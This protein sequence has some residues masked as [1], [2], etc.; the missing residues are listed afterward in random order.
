MSAA[1]AIALSLLAAEPLKLAAPGLSGVDVSEA[2]ATFFSDHFAQQLTLRGLQVTTSSQ[3][4]TLLGF[5]RQRNLLGCKETGGSCMAE[6]A[7]ALGV[8]GV[9]TG[10]VGKFDQTFQVNVSVVSALDGRTLSAF[11]RKVNGSAAVL[12]ALNDAADQMARDLP[13]VLKR[14]L[15]PLSNPPE[16]GK[17][18]PPHQPIAP[19]PTSTSS[20]PSPHDWFWLPGGLGLAAGVG[21][22]VFLLR[23]AEA[24]QLRIAAA[25]PANHR[26]SLDQANTI[27]AGGRRALRWGTPW[28]RSPPWALAPPGICSSPAPRRNLSQSGSSRGPPV[29]WSPVISDESTHSLR[30]FN[31]PPA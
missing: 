28:P 10:S 15:A 27:R 17:V 25:D 6:L 5:E 20:Q 9:V 3:I 11:S 31:R 16:I 24:D 13:R 29:W 26:L 19:E 8:D 18:P 7:A 30:A 1:L 2:Q 22:T 21:S 4:G 14:S 23:N 12:D